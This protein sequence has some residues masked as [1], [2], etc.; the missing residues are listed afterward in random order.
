VKLALVA[1]VSAAWHVPRAGV[2]AIVGDFIGGSQGTNDIGT[3]NP[4]GLFNPAADN[5]EQAMLDDFTVNLPFGWAPV[6]GGRHALDVQGGTPCRETKGTIL[7]NNDCVPGHFHRYLDPTP[8]GQRGI[9]NLYE[10]AP[11][12]G[13]RKSQRVPD[14]QRC[15]R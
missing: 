10:P 3:G 6:G 13:R 11:E 12:S 4:A 5:W 14:V 1:A 9:Y 2:P 8:P 7:F 15:E